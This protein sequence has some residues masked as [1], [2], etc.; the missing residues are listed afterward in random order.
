MAAYS[1]IRITLAIG[2]AYWQRTSGAEIVQ[3]TTASTDFDLTQVNVDDAN[4]TI[5]GVDASGITYTFEKAATMTIAF[6]S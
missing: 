2:V 5:S 3:T 4:D 6:V 1:A